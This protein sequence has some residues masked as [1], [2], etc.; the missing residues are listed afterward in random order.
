MDRLQQ[1]C[2]ALVH[3]EKFVHCQNNE[4]V[5]F[6]FWFQY[7]KK[8]AINLFISGL[9]CLQRETWGFINS[10]SVTIRRNGR[11]SLIVRAEMFGQLTSGLE[12]AWNKLKGEGLFFIFIFH[13]FS[14]MKNI[15]I[16][17]N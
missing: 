10:K 12:A 1:P 8:K 4:A 16:L 9:N 7:L 15:A 17:L 11:R 13:L 14:L 2:S 6:A 5:P 3:F